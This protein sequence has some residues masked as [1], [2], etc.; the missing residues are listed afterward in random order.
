M[1]SSISSLLAFGKIV[2]QARIECAVLVI[3]LPLKNGLETTIGVLFQFLFLL[4]CWA[5]FGE[6]FSMTV[7]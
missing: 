7:R 3:L 4:F 1:L 2:L 5:T 6:D